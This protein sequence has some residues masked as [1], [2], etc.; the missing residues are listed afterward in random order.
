MTATGTTPAT[1]WTAAT[2]NT[3]LVTPPLVLNVTIASP[4][5]ANQVVNAATITSTAGPFGTGE[6][7]NPVVTPVNQPA[8]LA[9]VKSVS[10]SGNVAPGATLTYTIVMTNSGGAATAVVVTDP[11][12]A[13]TTYVASRC[14]TERPPEPRPR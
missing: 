1:T 6:N 7:S 13:N 9:M 5:A 14:A 3:I 12:P 8:S 10:P 11:I 4:T 2:S